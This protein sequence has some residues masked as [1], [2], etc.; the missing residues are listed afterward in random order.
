MTDINDHLQIVLSNNIS[1][2]TDAHN[3]LVA[4]RFAREPGDEEHPAIVDIYLD[5]VEHDCLYECWWIAEPID[6]SSE[7]NLRI[8][9][10][11]DYAIVVQDNDEAATDDL[12]SLTRK[13]Y[14][15]LMAAVSAT[16]HKQM[17]KVWNYLGGINDGDGDLERY[18]RFSVGRAAAFA[19]MNVFDDAAPTGTGVGTRRD[20]GL[21][22]IA[23]ASK[24]P[25]ELVE[26]PR[27]ISAF[28]YPRQYG[29]SSPKFARGGSVIN[30]RHGLYLLSGT[31]A[32]VG[33]ESVH[34][35]DVE[36]QVDETFRNLTALS[37]SVSVLDKTSVLRVYLRDPDDIE[38]VAE[39]IEAQFGLHR[40]QIAFLRGNI[41]RSEL[42][43]EIDGVRV[44]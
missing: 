16:D 26:N 32:I 4:F 18:K 43:I 35:C 1:P 5:P 21:T 2:P 42:L 3:L 7:G 36:S 40:D 41:C 24:H 30:D 22:I 39:K 20:L 33:H 12:E 9:E 29:P 44:Q 10:C 27:Q 14:L 8:A 6:Y 19:E 13:A 37:E 15:E 23:L 28:H 38:V 25:L 11:V 34:P 31:A 17:A